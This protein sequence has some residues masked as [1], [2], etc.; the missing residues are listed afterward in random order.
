MKYRLPTGQWIC[1]GLQAKRG[2]I[3]ASSGT[4]I[5]DVA[6]IHNQASMM[7]GHEVFDPD[8]NKK[9]LIDHSMAVAGGTVTKQAKNW[10]GGRLD[11]S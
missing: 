6:A 10:L 7:L 9:H 8:T 3:D 11:A 1:F 2:K 4:K 5:Q